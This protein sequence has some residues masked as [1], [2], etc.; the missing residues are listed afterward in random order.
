MVMNDTER[1]EN[2]HI[3]QHQQIDLSKFLDRYKLVNNLQVN[4]NI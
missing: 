1:D 4:W 2:L 3:F